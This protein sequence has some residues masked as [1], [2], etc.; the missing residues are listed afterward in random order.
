MSEPA[1]IKLHC[2]IDQLDRMNEDGLELLPGGYKS[3][4]IKTNS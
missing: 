1:R 2:L 3:N 4:I